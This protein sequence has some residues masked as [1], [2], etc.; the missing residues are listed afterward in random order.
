MYFVPRDFLSYCGD[1]L[2]SLHSLISYKQRKTFFTFFNYSKSKKTV[3]EIQLTYNKRYGVIYMEIT[4]F[5]EER[6]IE[7][8]SLETRIERINV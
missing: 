2:F 1:I 3:L 4:N 6:S 5:N 7:L 8:A